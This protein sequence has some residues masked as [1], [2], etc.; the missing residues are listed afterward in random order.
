MPYRKS[1]MA[2]VRMT[3]KSNVEK[4]LFKFANLLVF[5]PFLTLVD[6]VEEV[7]PEDDDADEDE[8]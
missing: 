8:V 5:S 4:E 6:K 7:P 1:A 3:I 2:I